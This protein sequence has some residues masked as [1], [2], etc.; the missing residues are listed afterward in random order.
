MKDNKKVANNIVMLYIMNITQLV[1]PLITLPY[2]T[3]VLS[4][5][6]YGVVSYV[7][8]IMTYATLIIEFG[9]ILSG[10][11][12]VVEAKNDKEKLGKIVG[13]ITECKLLLSILSFLVL[14]FMAYKIPILKRHILFTFLSF[15]TPF[16]SIFLFD[17]LF[18]GLEKMQ[19]VTLRYLIM[20]G[21]STTLTFVF[22]KNETQ[23]NLIP[24]LDILGSLFAIIWINI[25]LK[26]MGI[27]MTFDNLT[28]VLNSL[29]VS[30]TYFLSDVATTAFGALN[31]F[32]VGIYLS[33]ADVAF[34]G[35]IMSFVGA[36][37]SMY[38]PISDGIYPHM[39]KTKSLKLFK[40]IL[41]FFVPILAIGGVI[42]FYGAKFIMLIIGGEKYIASAI[43]LK[44]SVPLLIISFFSILCGWPLLGAINKVKE[45]TLTTI[46]TAILQIIGILFLIFSQKFSIENLII[47]RTLTE[48]FLALSRVSF[49]KKYRTLFKD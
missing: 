45:T 43:Y 26:K 27:Q 2:L 18:R 37:Q 39:I 21:V 30:F 6:G 8:S 12:D 28:S 20:K 48:L 49:V 4:V 25:E 44:E 23:L 1:L 36:V 5:D 41:L 47:V 38:S 9:F 42:T 46:I 15:G 24:V 16:L 19:I 17:Y 3:R 7:K 40:K 10:T 11:K 13:R 33:A 31:T 29:R 32:V 14:I 22:I 34:W 35:V